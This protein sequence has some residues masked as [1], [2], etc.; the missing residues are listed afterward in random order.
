MKAENVLTADELAVIADGR[1]ADL[2]ARKLAGLSGDELATAKR[3]NQARQKAIHERSKQAM[4]AT[5]KDRRKKFW[6]D[7]WKDLVGQDTD[8]FGKHADHTTTA[9]F[10]PFKLMGH[11]LH[12][13]MRS[14]N[15]AQTEVEFISGGKQKRFTATRLAAGV[16]AGLTLSPLVGLFGLKRKNL[17]ANSITVADTTGQ[18]YSYEF[19]AKESL[20]AQQ[21][22]TKVQA[23]QQGL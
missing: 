2:P 22:V 18:S 15:L 3:W 5:A 10:G 1:E 9:S 8:T 6:S 12:A 19:K 20:K 16:T 21:F 23:V 4:K 17:K 13:G 14:F 11:T 7:A